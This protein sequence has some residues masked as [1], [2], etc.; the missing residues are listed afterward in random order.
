MVEPKELMLLLFLVLAFASGLFATIWP[1][2]VVSF[3]QRLGWGSD[4]PLF[5]GFYYTTQKR[6]RRTGTVLAVVTF[7]LGVIRLMTHHVA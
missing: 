3:Y 5:G 6:A 1:S 4:N 2:K 7:A